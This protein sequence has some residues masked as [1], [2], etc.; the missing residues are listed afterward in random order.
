MTLGQKLKE[1][2]REVGFTQEQL[3]RKTMCI[4]TSCY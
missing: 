2:R 1:A 4:K 3:H